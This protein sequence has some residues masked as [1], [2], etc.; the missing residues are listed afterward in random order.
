MTNNRKIVEV[1]SRR[2]I[3]LGK[4]AIHDLYLV[5]VEPGGTIILTP[6][7]VI[8]RAGGEKTVPA[9]E[10]GDEAKS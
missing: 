3:T 9:I 2:R 8:P 6:A 5:D 10:V 4:L 7:V 1:D